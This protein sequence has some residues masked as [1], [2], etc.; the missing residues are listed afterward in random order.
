MLNI[1][2][3]RAQS[4]L[5]QFIVLIIALVFIFW[6]VGTN[7][8]TK[9]N[10]LATVNGV[11]IPYENYRRTYDSMVD[12]L[13]VQFGGSIPAGFLEGLGIKQQVMQQLIRAELLRQGGKEM[14]VLVSKAAT[15]DEIRKMDVFQVNGQ[16]DINRYKQILSQNRMTPVSFEA[17]LQNDLLAKKVTE[18]IRG[19]AA[20]PDSAVKAKINYDQEQI[21]LSYVTVNSSD[22]VDKVVIDEEKLAQWFEKNKRNYLSDPQVRLK[23]LFFNFKDDLAAATPTDEELKQR[24]ERDIQKYTSQEQRHARHILFKVSE[25]DSAEVRAEQKKKAEKVL[26]LAKDGGD[27]AE[28]AKE[29]SEGPTAPVGGDLGFFNKGAMVQQFDKAVFKMEPGE[30][31]G[32]VETVFGYHI[33]KLE[34][35]RP[36][37]VKAFEDVKDEIAKEMQQQ[38]VNDIT[39][40]KAQKAYEDIIRSGSLDNYKEQAGA[41]VVETEYFSKNEQPGPPVNDP[42]FSQAAFSLKNG[43]LSSLVK[44]AGGYAIIFVDDIKAPEVPEL[45]A[46][47]KKVEKD[48][49]KERSIELAK[50]KATKLLDEAKEKKTLSEV[51]LSDEVKTTEFIVRSKIAQAKDVPVQVVQ[52]A[53]KLSAHDVFPEK[54]L[55]QGE[56]FYLYEV[57]ER[58]QGEAGTDE[59]LLKRVQ[60]QLEANA[61]SRLLENWLAWMQSNAKVWVNEQILQ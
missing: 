27:F 30:I 29:Y 37:G 61:Q 32:I 16:F 24:Y 50:E 12:N 4:T 47:R 31:S 36:A 40:Q 9:R 49:K 54:P 45:N 58:K 25:S 8:G 2:R 46:V 55:E 38:R 33:I 14:G 57:V 28:L 53:F 52:E 41:D 48:Y 21:K 51:G 26:A 5:I 22:F 59:E 20:A 56:T 34:E 19:F 6:G 60:E 44:I 42:E 1:L 43:E 18:A 13:R 3:K 11:E 7:L 10:A 39:R 15:Q 23:Y 35:V 17:G